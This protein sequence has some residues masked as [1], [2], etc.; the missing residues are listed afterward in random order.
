[1]RAS[2]GASVLTAS[3]TKACCTFAAGIFRS[4]MS[5]TS[6]NKNA[7]VGPYS[8]RAVSSRMRL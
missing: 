7:I 6:E 3:K 2:A 4:M 5:G 1:M 8:R